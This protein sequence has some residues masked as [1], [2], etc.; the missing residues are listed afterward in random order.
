M[1]NSPASDKLTSI[2]GIDDD[3]DEAEGVAANSGPTLDIFK[4]VL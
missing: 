1:R 2:K 3:D 4:I